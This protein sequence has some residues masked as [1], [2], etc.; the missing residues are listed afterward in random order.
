[1]LHRRQKSKR[2][3]IGLQVSPVAK[4]F[5]YALTLAAGSFQYTGCGRFTSRFG[6]GR[7]MSI[8]RITDATGCVLD[9]PQREQQVGISL[10]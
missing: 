4:R 8:T 5:K 6:S 7:H 1:M 2:V 3:E 10:A 9:S